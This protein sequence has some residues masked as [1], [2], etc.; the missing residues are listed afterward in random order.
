MVQKFFGMEE[1]ELTSPCQRPTLTI[2][3]ACVV[4]GIT[5]NRTNTWPPL[6]TSNPTPI[7]S[8]TTG[9]SRKP[10]GMN[11][12]MQPPT[13]VTTTPPDKLRLRNI[14]PSWKAMPSNVSPISPPLYLILFL[15][16][17]IS[18]CLSLSVLYPHLIPQNS[19]SGEQSG[20]WA[21]CFFIQPA[22][23]WWTTPLSMRTVCLI[24]AR[25]QTTWGTASVPCCHSMPRTVLP[26]VSTCNG[27]AMSQNVVSNWLQLVFITLI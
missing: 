13:R 1:P 15:S 19:F 7:S 17:F 4:L 18:V 16:V 27:G 10:A 11:R 22:I 24:C 25:A 8:V 3:R 20:P 23:L 21:S 5:T 26:K 6:V 12:R 14:V 2:P 9:N